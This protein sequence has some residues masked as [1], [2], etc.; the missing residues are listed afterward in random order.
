MPIP[1]SQPTVSL[2]RC[3]EY[4]PREVTAAVREALEAL[5]GVQELARSGR[6]ALLKPNIV[7]PRRPETAVCTHP[8]I[9]RAVAEFL[10]EAGC[11]L[12]VADQPT[13]ARV[14]MTE[15]VF[16]LPGY[17][18]A[19]R[20]LPAEWVLPTAVGYESYSVPRPQQV[21]VVYLSRV[22]REVDFVVNLPKL[23]THMQTRLTAAVKNTFGLVAPRQRMDLH[24]LG[25]GARL[26]GGI[27]DCFGAAPPALSL[28]DA[29]VAMEGPGPARGRPRLTRW[30][31]AS[32]DAV[33]L[34]AWAAELAGFGPE[35][36]ATTAAAAAAGHGEGD[37]SRTAVVGD[38][39][40]A[41]RVRL[42]RAPRLTEHLPSWAGALGRR[43]LYTRP[44]VHA[45]RCT[46]CGQC[47]ASCPAGCIAVAAVAQIDYRRCLECFCCMEA[48]PCEAIEVTRG[49]LNRLA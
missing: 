5:P 6:R 3:S 22:L 11:D 39:P 41:L 37:R 2:R 33:A 24:A 49:L 36:I 32:T 30:V 44:R 9:V 14:H 35:E 26:S 13:Y 45:Q 15:E 31:A 48:C 17:R 43:W 23:K 34:D 42:R 47:A 46:A 28:L 21:S 1:A 27:A 8:E 16:S 19:L 10:H 25:P 20:G 29:V 18:E 12:L 40:Q 38:D 4:T 7:N